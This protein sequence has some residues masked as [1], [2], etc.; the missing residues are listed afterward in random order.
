M[1]I[2]HFPRVTIGCSGIGRFRDE[3]RSP[4][5]TASQ[6]SA[7]FLSSAM[8]A[9]TPAERLSQQVAQAKALA[10]RHAYRE[11]AAVLE[12]LRAIST[13]P[14][15]RTGR[16]TLYVRA[17]Y[18]ALGGNPDKAMTTLK[19]AADLEVVPLGDGLA[20]RI[21]RFARPPRIQGAGGASPKGSGVVERQPSPRHS[22][23]AN[24]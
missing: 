6:V 17:R 20:N 7:C 19:Y 13:S 3:I 10:D 4:L 21:Y 2:G 15:F 8:W 24:A 12:K 16:D 1:I 14:R 18:E 9:G 11:A 23:K 5:S 22:L